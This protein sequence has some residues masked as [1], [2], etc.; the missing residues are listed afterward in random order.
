MDKIYLNN[1]A[2][3]YPK[4][5]GVSEAVCEALENLPGAANRGGIEDF[6]VLGAAREALAGFMGVSNPD[7]IGLG[8]NATWGLN[9]AIHGLELSA[10]D[11]VLTTTAEHNS[12][13]RP[14]YALSRSRGSTIHYLPV[15]AAGRVDVEQW[16]EALAELKPT[17][18]VLTHASNV[19]GAVNDVATLTK[20]A[21]ERHA[22]MLLDM[23]QSLGCVPCHLEEWQVDMAAFTGHK[24]LLGPQGTGGLYVRPDINL[25]PYL[26]GG[27]G[28]HSDLDTMPDAMPLHI[29]AGTGNEPGFYGLL[30]ALRW[31]HAHPWGA[32]TGACAVAVAGA[33]AVM[34]AGAGAVTGADADADLAP[35]LQPPTD[36][37]PHK[38]PQILA[39]LADGLRSLGARVIDPGPPCTPLLS[40]TLDGFT[41]TYIGETLLDSYDIIVRTG[42]HC[43][44]RIFTSL[45]IDPRLGT[46]RVSLSRF[47]ELADI[48][49]LL[50]AVSEIIAAG[51]E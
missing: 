3:S 18:C 38:T 15:D 25:T 21:H 6:D 41:P 49:A 11:A 27:T 43:A 29:E 47:T 10:T 17:L 46:V 48:E 50:E 7:G 12:V 26:S 14:L 22:L 8:P 24:Y 33:G 28:I 45:G 42:L 30:A 4:A 1:G 34:G 2:T 39:R 13:L 51:P 9:L 37:L 36:A 32:A 16:R 23:A 19:T 5:P 40:F 35:D 31:Q 20:L 44:P